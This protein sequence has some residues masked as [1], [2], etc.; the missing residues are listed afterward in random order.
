MRL[1]RNLLA[2]SVL[3]VPAVAGAQNVLWYTD[4][5]AYRSSMTA[6][7]AANGWTITFFGSADAAPMFSAYD[8]L[9]IG[10]TQSVGNYSGITSNTAAITAAR[11]SRTFLS[12]QDADWH[13]TYGGDP[14][15]G[16]ASLFLKNAINWAM[17][18]TAL[19][20]VA[21]ADY[22]NGYSC[23]AGSFLY[24]E[25]TLGGGPCQVQFNRHNQTVIIPGPTAGYPVNA[26]LTSAS[27]SNWGNSYHNTF[28]AGLAGYTTINLSGDYADAAVTLVTERE[29]AGGTDIVPEPA[30]IVLMASGLVG[31]GIMARRRR[32][33]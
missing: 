8:A 29:A 27:L 7:A 22:N 12:G 30:S 24:N 11:G 13:R 16:A 33:V 20:I 21:L 23:Q 18:G 5:T 15:G 17:A 32:K 3:A 4:G 19:G 1:M 6:L 31:V 25:L 9:V 10:W 26:G 28:T 2:A 14:G